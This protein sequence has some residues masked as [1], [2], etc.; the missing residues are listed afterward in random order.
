MKHSILIVDDEIRLLRAL[1]RE[2]HQDYEV[3]ICDDPQQALNIIKKN[4][5]TVI[6]TDYMMP[7]MDGV[8]FLQKV[9]RIDNSS[10]RIMLTGHS[11]LQVAIEALNT[12]EIFRFILKPHNSEK[13]SSILNEAVSK[14]EKSKIMMEKLTYDT[15]TKALN[16]DSIFQ[17]LKLE[18]HNLK[19]EK[20]NLSIAMLD[21]D[22]FKQIN[23][24]YGHP[25]G[26][27]VLKNVVSCIKKNIRGM[28]Y[29]GRYGGEEFL[30][31]FNH[32]GLK[33]TK[34][35]LER[36]LRKIENIKFKKKDVKVTVSAGLIDC[37]NETNKMNVLIDKVDKRLYRAKKLGK[38]RI[39]T[40]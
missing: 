16:R 35:V 10:I 3:V 15:L 22:D 4:Q 31:L 37:S 40:K 24:K 33:A 2:L 13:L 20:N 7:E 6:I 28:D 8:D 19:K 25:F 26:D 11:D 29:L 23:D 17:K 30:I 38:N 39:C 14:Y 27:K 5:F 9:K 18:L 34:S 36:I 12:G 21:I 1:R 32:S